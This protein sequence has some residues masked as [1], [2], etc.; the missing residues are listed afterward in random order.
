[1][2]RSCICIVQVLLVNKP[3]IIPDY[4]YA[5]SVHRL[6][7]AHAVNHTEGVTL[8]ITHGNKAGHICTSLS[9]TQ[10]LSTSGTQSIVPFTGHNMKVV[11]LKGFCGHSESMDRKKGRKSM[12]ILYISSQLSVASS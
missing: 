1:M 6:A 8:S 2:K 12:P 9:G 11:P 5:K 3:L 7:V 4:T 10:S